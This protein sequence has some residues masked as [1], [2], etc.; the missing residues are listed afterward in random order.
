MPLGSSSEAPVIN[1]APRRD[2]R[3]RMLLELP[4][5]CRRGCEGAL[6]R[7]W[8]L[9]RVLAMVQSE[10]LDAN[11]SLECAVQWNTAADGECPD[12][13][14]VLSRNQGCREARFLVK[15]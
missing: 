14:S 6:G 13:L 4:A 3:N 15:L 10:A 9:A 2:H 7:R 5:A 11:L 12:V 1:P 8:D